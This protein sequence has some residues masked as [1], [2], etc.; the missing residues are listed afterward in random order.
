MK[1]YLVILNT[2]DIRLNSKYSSNSHNIYYTYYKSI[3]R[4]ISCNLNALDKI[5]IVI[6]RRVI[7]L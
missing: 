5:K 1:T 7:S 2:F 3:M 6:L 4:I